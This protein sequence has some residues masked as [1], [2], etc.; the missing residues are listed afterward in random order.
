MNETYVLKYDGK[1]IAY[2]NLDNIWIER[3][4]KFKIGKIKPN[5]MSGYS[6]HKDIELHMVTQGEL[7]VKL[8]SEEIYAKVG[9]L[10]IASSFV[11]HSLLYDGATTTDHLIIDSKYL[12]ENGID[13]TKYR[14]REKIDDENIR[15]FFSQLCVQIKTSFMRDVVMK[16]IILQ[17]VA[18]LLRN[19]ADRISDEESNIDLSV[20]GQNFEY[21]RRAIDYI[22]VNI[23]NNL[24]VDD[25]S[26]YVGL[27]RYHFMRVFKSVTGYT[28]SEYV[29]IMKC[30]H[31]K[32]IL[33]DGKSNVTDAALSSGFNSVSYFTKV[34]KR[35]TGKLPSE[36]MTK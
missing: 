22:S 17:L 32:V 6:I 10:V 14:F 18:Y 33:F 27:T 15:E 25:I 24:S 23:Q 26:D 31:A 30:E 35:Y 3:P 13:V 36:Y 21:A 12:L 9:Q 16:G 29:N 34:F 1:R 28:V 8:G 5:R 7:C 19:H 4:Y 11:P 20:Y 2:E